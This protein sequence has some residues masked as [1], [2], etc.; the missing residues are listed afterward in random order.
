MKI[1]IFALIVLLAT[2]PG[3]ADYEGLKS[4]K[5]QHKSK[6]AVSNLSTKDNNSCNLVEIKYYDINT[7]DL[8]ILEIRYDLHFQQ[9]I[10]DGICVFKYKGDRKLNDLLDAIQKEQKNIKSIREYKPYKF[11]IF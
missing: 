9:C 4:Y 8:E 11:K 5:S 10:A 7:I 3:Y 6:D 1:K 2:I